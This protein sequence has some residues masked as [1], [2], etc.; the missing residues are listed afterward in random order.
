VAGYGTS[1]SGQPTTAAPTVL[2][3]IAPGANSEVALLDASAAY[4]DTGTFAHRFRI[5]RST[6]GTAGT[7]VTAEKALSKSAAA[8]AT[9]VT[10]FT[11]APTISGLPLI[12]LGGT[13]GTAITGH[14]R[15]VNPRPRY[16]ITADVSAARIELEEAVGNGVVMVR[17]ALFVEPGPTSFRRLGGRS[18]R[19]RRGH[20]FI[21]DER[22]SF[23]GV[24]TG[25]KGQAFASAYCY[26]DPSAW[27]DSILP[28]QTFLLLLNGTGDVTSDNTDTASVADSNLIAL[29]VAN[30]DTAAVSDSNLVAQ[31]V[32]HTDTASVSDSNTATVGV[33]S[34]N[35]D[36]AAVSD[37]NL[38]ALG[39]ANTDAAAVADS[40]LVALTAV[41]SDTATVSDS[42][43]AQVGVSSAN[44]DT[45]AVSDSNL[46]AL[47]VVHADTAAVSDSNALRLGVAHTDTATVSDSNTA[48][49]GVFSANVDTATV[50]D[51]S[52]VALGV[53][54]SDFAAVSDSNTAQVTTPGG[55][56]AP[57][58]WRPFLTHS[59]LGQQRPWWARYTIRRQKGR[60]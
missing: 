55:P 49:V 59:R 5:I 48:N 46:V 56:A 50:S 58:P 20:I 32:A 21:Q 43:T 27:P 37:S 10:D 42:N 18:Y 12:V 34:A 35:T 30:T 19:P 31:T 14:R 26:L 53:V 44:T 47:T 41:H 2:L 33:T 16:P 15:W 28:V 23:G 25:H 17:A 1:A 3:G 40:N 8:G 13:I 38:V 24:S 45:A 22:R 36:T 51:T 60:P 52:L 6:G 54:H 39:V 4:A 57:S 11:A 29:S 7:T 9:T